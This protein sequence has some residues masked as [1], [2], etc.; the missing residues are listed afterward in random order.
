MQILRKQI[1]L[2]CTPG[3]SL[4]ECSSSSAHTAKPYNQDAAL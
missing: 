3:L 2:P 4:K 1:E